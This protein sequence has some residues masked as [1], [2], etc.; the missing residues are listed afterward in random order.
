MASTLDPWTTS[1]FVRREY[2][3]GDSTVPLERECDDRVYLYRI[4]PLGPAMREE[5][6]LLSEDSLLWLSIPVGVC[7]CVMCVSAAVV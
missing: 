7:A 1:L 4:G 2:S 6:S 5:D 3:I